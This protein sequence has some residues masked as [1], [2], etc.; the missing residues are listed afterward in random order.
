M[1][2]FCT[3]E[4]VATQSDPTRCPKESSYYNYNEKLYQYCQDDKLFT[5]VCYD[6]CISVANNDKYNCTQK[7]MDACK[8]KTTELDKKATTTKTFKNFCG[9]M[10]PNSYYNEYYKKLNQA[11]EQRGI[12]TNMIPERP[13]CNYPYCSRTR[14]KLYITIWS[15]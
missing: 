12:S 10:L 13:E 9:C 8:N 11:F 2:E 15:K 3:P 5:D 4:I 14:I 7:L 6:Y 1:N